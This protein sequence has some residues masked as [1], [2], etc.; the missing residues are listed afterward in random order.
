MA[1]HVHCKVHGDLGKEWGEVQILED[2]DEIKPGPIHTLSFDFDGQNV[3]FC[4]RCIRDLLRKNLM[5][6]T[7]VEHP[8]E[9]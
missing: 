3:E 6:V 9:A 2:G 5:P 4:L 7:I 8:R 1:T